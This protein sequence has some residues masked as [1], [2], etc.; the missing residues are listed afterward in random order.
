MGRKDNR[1]MLPL[2]AL[3]LDLPV[4]LHQQAVILTPEFPNK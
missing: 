4:Q 3:K 1:I 2:H